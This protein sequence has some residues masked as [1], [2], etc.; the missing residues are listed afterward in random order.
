MKCN[1][2]SSY[3]H[4]FCFSSHC[5]TSSF[6]D[7]L[8]ELNFGNAQDVIL[9]ATSRQFKMMPAMLLFMTRQT[10]VYR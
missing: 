3:Y 8:L 1:I 7:G 2:M 6:G 9:N 5:S 4:M 10:E